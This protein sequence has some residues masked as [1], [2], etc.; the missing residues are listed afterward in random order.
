MQVRKLI[1]SI[2]L[3]KSGKGKSASILVQNKPI[4][5]VH[6]RYSFLQLKMAACVTKLLNAYSNM[7]AST[8][9]AYVSN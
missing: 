5:G 8:P 7:K 2:V 9:L 4:C 1:H 3:L 6:V